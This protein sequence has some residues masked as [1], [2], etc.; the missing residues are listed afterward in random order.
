MAHNICFR[1]VQ[2]LRLS[3]VLVA[4]NQHRSIPVQMA[5]CL[6]SA[7][8]AQHIACAGTISSAFIVGVGKEYHKVDRI[9]LGIALTILRSSS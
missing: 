3:W 4:K 7:L 9:A 5:R 1:N 8:C 6:L 2:D